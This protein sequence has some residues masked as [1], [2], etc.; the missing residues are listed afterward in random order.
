MKP[1]AALLLA[2]AAFS[3][4]AV[5]PIYRCGPDGRQYSQ[6]PCPGGKLVEASDPR[7]AAQRTE[8]K[9]VAALERKQ[10][11]DMERERRAQQA[12]EKP[13]QAT[14]INAKPTEE[15]N[16]A[17]S[18]ASKPGRKK[19]HHKAHGDDEKD[20]IAVAPGSHKK[21]KKTSAP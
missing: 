9:R 16:P 8:A 19:K 20:F 21:A 17:A 10:A 5:G 6:T 2:C 14:G 11:S 1:V 15:A 13:A 18:A 7:S 12:A 3:A 4:V